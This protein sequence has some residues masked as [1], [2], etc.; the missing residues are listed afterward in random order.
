MRTMSSLYEVQELR[1]RLNTTEADTEGEVF[2]PE[3]ALMTLM[4]DHRTDVFNRTMSSH[5]VLF[6]SIFTL[7]RVLVVKHSPDPP[8]QVFS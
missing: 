8:T 5:C 2:T 1:G 3:A 6:K 4:K 7:I